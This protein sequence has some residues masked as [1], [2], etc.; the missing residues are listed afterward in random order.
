MDGFLSNEPDHVSNEPNSL[1]SERR[2]RAREGDEE[3]EVIHARSQRAKTQITNP[4]VRAGELLLRESKRVKVRRT[5]P[6]DTEYGFCSY[7]V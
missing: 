7:I 6:S 4:R 2:I 5:Y 1:R 3:D